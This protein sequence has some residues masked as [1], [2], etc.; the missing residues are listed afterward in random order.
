MAKYEADAFSQMLAGA[1]LATARQLVKGGVAP[2]DSVKI[3]AASLIAGALGRKALTDLGVPLRTVQRWQAE[4]RRATEGFGD[5]PPA[6]MINE[7]LA[8]MG[9]PFRVTDQ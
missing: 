2:T 4:G 3:A 5:V 8:F 9:L 1:L 7:L 6:E